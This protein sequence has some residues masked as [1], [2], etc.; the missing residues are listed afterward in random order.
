MRVN[1]SKPLGGL[2]LGLTLGC[3][4]LAAAQNAPISAAPVANVP[5][6]VAANPAAPVAANISVLIVALDDLGAPGAGMVPLISPPIVP[7][8]AP[9]AIAPAD[10]MPAM[11][12]PTSFG[13]PLWQWRVSAQKKTKAEKKTRERSRRRQNFQYGSRSSFALPARQPQQCGARQS[14]G[15][16]RY[17][18]AR[19]WVADHRARAGRRNFR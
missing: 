18:A 10:G 12:T 2:A 13:A 6:A 14:T 4:S 16:R 7:P 15:A 3:A 11:V 19:S 17:H 5:V 1:P 9:P 8:V